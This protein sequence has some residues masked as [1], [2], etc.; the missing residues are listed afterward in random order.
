MLFRSGAHDVG[1]FVS[2]G[3]F[4]KDARTEARSHETRRLTLLD[5]NETL[6]LWIDNYDGIDQQRRRLL[7]LRPVFFLATD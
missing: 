6:Q 7:P 3:G 5:L 2:T 4:T 1:I